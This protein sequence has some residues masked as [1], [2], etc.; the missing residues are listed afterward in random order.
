MDWIQVIVILA[1]NLGVVIP[2]F[3]NSDSKMEAN[4]RET[5]DILKGIREDMKD[6]HEAMKDFHGRL[7][8]IEERRIK[9]LEK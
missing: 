4:R 7:C 5:V 1:A 6:F 3:L 8:T 2:L 9:I